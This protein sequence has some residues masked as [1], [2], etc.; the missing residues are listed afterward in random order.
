MKKVLRVTEVVKSSSMKAP[1]WVAGQLQTVYMQGNSADGAK[2]KIFVR[3]ETNGKLKVV[4]GRTYFNDQ[5][6]LYF[7]P[8]A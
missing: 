5:N 8:K 6:V 7:L 2:A 1:A 3:D 4:R